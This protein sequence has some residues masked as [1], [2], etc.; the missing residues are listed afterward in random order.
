MLVDKPRAMPECREMNSQEFK[1]GMT[2]RHL[3]EAI[4]LWPE[5]SEDGELTEVWISSTDHG[6]SNQAVHLFPLN[7]RIS[8]A[9][10]SCDLLI[11]PRIQQSP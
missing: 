1:N 10:F 8:D 6:T 9:H 3:K 11:A 7:V 2:V 4:A 5:I